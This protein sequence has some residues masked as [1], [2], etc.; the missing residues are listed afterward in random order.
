M[1]SVT[2]S[3]NKKL[4]EW[5]Y[6]YSLKSTQ[7]STVVPEFGIYFYFKKLCMWENE[8]GTPLSH[9]SHP[10]MWLY[11]YISCPESCKSVLYQSNLLISI[12][13][14]IWE[15]RNLPTRHHSNSIMSV[16]QTLPDGN[17]TLIV[18]ICIWLSWGSILFQYTICISWM[19]DFIKK[20][21]KKKGKSFTPKPFPIG[22]CL[23]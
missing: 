12:S 5:S 8:E 23:P 21:K 13:V 22:I 9:V 7:F 6:S 15:N 19:H 2:P 4:V 18:E 10:S 17:C 1:V 14:F 16:K 3:I 20:R 11:W